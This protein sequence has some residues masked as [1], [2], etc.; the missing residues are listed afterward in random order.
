MDKALKLPNLMG[1]VS[2]DTIKDSQ[3]ETTPQCKKQSRY[4]RQPHAGDG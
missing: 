1:S 3:E 2:S 4:T